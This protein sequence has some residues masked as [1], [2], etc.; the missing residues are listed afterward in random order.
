MNATYNQPEISCLT[1][2]EQQNHKKDNIIVTSVS[3]FTP[4][5]FSSILCELYVKAFHIIIKD[6]NTMIK[7]KCD[8]S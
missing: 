6:E 7:L 1:E 3:H 4:F 8:R 5:L 2:K